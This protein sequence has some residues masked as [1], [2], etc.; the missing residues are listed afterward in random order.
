MYRVVITIFE[1]LKK[2]MAVKTAAEK[3]YYEE[4]IRKKTDL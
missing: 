4:K 1:R 2:V 3:E